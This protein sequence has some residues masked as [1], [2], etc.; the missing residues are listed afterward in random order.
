MIDPGSALVALLTGQVV[1]AAWQG[2][3]GNTTHAAASMAYRR[4]LRELDDDPDERANHDIA[5]TVR[6]AQLDALGVLLNDYALARAAAW[7]A[8]AMRP[9]AFEQAAADFCRAQ[10]GLAKTD[11]ASLALPVTEAL[12]TALDQALGPTQAGTLAGD[13]ARMLDGMAEDA[14]LADLARGDGVVV[15]DDFASHLRHGSGP[16]YPRFLDAFADKIRE[17]VKRNTRFRDILLASGIAE[18]KA[19]GFETIEL[20]LRIEQ[21]YGVGQAEL[22]AAVARLEGATQ[23]IE[24]TLAA[25]HAS[26][27]DVAQGMASLPGQVVEQLM[28]EFDA[29]GRTASAASEGLERRAVIALA[30]RLRPEDVQDFD[31]AIIELERAVEI[32]LEAIARGER[33][34]NLGAFVDT[35]LAR[36]ARTTAA[37]DFDAGTRAVD[38]GLL[39]LDRQDAEQRRR[40]AEQ[41]D[42]MRRSR[43]ALL[44]AGVEQDTLRR[45]AAGVARRFEAIAATEH[46]DDTAAQRGSLRKRYDT[47][48]EEGGDRGV[49]FA[50]SIAIAVASRMAVTAADAQARAY[51]DVL[52]GNALQTLGARESGT[53]RLEQ[54]VEAYRA[55]L[56]EYSRDRVPL[57]WAA[58]QN[59]LGN[60]LRTL[61]ERES[62]TARLEQAVEAYR[63]AL[64]EYSRDRVPLDWA[65]T[66]NNLGTALSTLGERESGTARLEQAVEAYR[67]ALEEYTRDRVP[68]DWA[69]TQNNLGNALWRLGERESGT[70]RLEQAVEAFRAALEERTRERVPLDWATTQNNLGTALATLGAR[71][72]GTARL[73]QAV[74]A[75]RAA[76]EERTRE[77][78]PLAWAGTQNNLGNALATLGARESGTARLEQAVEAFRAAL[79]EYTHDRV[80]LNWAMTQNNLGNAL[81]T[82]GERESGTARLKQAVV[83]YSEAL[84][85]FEPAHADHYTGIAKRNRDRVTALIAA[86]RGNL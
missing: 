78:V 64:E 39:E 84:S 61:G 18:L 48:M 28:A 60:A 65:M 7:A 31:Q 16:A 80:P 11:L 10:R 32:A 30:R 2:V 72:S 25:T 56:E 81:R 42:L 53:A 1:S 37:G 17:A 35:V 13:R 59:N 52:D 43:I 23:R 49:N 20:L 73:E 33:G 62:G 27:Q 76:L 71:E 55:A 14:V 63:A 67:A 66:Q 21:R 6:L 77:R 26:V 45:D 5:R 8:G 50:L 36:L 4:V 47:A 12:E 70:A 38:E 74:E 41:R 83:A 54:A 57:D 86:R 44:E 9:V 58:T 22:L 68:L 19:N 51:A 3:V 34:T 69:M 75:Y 40:E 85:V 24:K 29:R 46:P 79:E 82:L 15:P